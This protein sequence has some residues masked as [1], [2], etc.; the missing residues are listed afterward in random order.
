MESSI[1]NES[2]IEH[3]LNV[4]K[5]SKNSKRSKQLKSKR[6]TRQSIYQRDHFMQKL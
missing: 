1:D 6:G 2:K 3:T 4:D 5:S